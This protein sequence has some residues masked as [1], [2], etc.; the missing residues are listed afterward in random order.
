MLAQHPEAAGHAAEDDALDLAESTR[1]VRLGLLELYLV[2]E[3]VQL[4]VEHFFI[5]M[6]RA[7]E[8]ALVAAELDDLTRFTRFFFPQL[9]PLQLRTSDL[10]LATLY[11]DLSRFRIRQRAAIN[12]A[13]NWVI[14]L[15]LNTDM[16][17]L[18]HAQLYF[19]QAVVVLEA[20]QLCAS[21][22]LVDGAD[23]GL[24]ENVATLPSLLLLILQPDVL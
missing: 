6:I 23:F 24:L 5:Y 15:A 14:E 18:R 1:G 20:R 22:L 2:V 16:H 11:S 13:Q 10:G 4:H 8:T 9:L 17:L 7:F 21:E 3:F 19:V 12:Y